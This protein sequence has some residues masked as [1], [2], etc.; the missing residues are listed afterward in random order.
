MTDDPKTK[1]A[2]ARVHERLTFEVAV[3]V[4]SDTNFFAGLS[5]NISE[6][7]IF[8]ATHVTYPIGTR[9]EIRLLLPA[10]EEPTSV[11]TEVRWVRPHVEGDD[12]VTGGSAQL[13]RTPDPAVMAKIARFAAKREPIYYEDWSLLAGD[14]GARL[15]DAPISLIASSTATTTRRATRMGM[16][17][18][19][20][21]S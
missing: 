11:M 2:D 19:S 1:P 9:L 17:V 12:A 13:L 4:V 5:L 20:A 18:S 10:D 21:A 7:G 15:P 14:D 16:S 8:V 6:G 3:S